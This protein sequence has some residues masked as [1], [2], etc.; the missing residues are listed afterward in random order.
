MGI[1]SYSY[2]WG[3]CVEKYNTQTLEWVE[4]IWKK[5]KLNYN[6]VIQNSDQHLQYN[7]GKHVHLKLLTFLSIKKTDLNAER[8]ATLWTVLPEKL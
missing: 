6:Q 7:L 1:L 8:S 2:Q 5:I 4:H 3:S